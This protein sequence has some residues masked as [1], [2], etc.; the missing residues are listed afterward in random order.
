MWLEDHDYCPVTK[1]PLPKDVQLVP[2][3]LLR[4]MILGWASENAPDLLVGALLGALVAGRKWGC[5]TSLHAC[6]RAE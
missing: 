6:R 1:Q 4:N 2:N 3:M 5:G